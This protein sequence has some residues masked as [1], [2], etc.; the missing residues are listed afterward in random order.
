MHFVGSWN[1][2]DILL[3]KGTKFQIL[4]RKDSTITVFRLE[5][6]VVATRSNTNSNFNATRLTRNLVST[7]LIIT[8]IITQSTQ[9]GGRVTRF[10]RHSLLG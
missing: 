8:Q 7:A 10:E 6:H 9:R 4:L 3:E 2:R 1:K 5:T